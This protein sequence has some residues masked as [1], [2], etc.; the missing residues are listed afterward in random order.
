IPA[1]LPGTA[2]KLLDNAQGPRWS[3]DGRHLAFMRPGSTSGDELWIADADGSNAHQVVKPVGGRH[4]HW[5][6]WS[7]DGQYVYFIYSPNSFND[8]PAEI[9]RVPSAGGPIQR[10]VATTR[11]AVFPAPLLDGI[12]Y[13][14][15]AAGADLG[16]WW[17]RN[18]GGES[19]PVTAGIGE[20]ADVQ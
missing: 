15:D 19:L 4:L 10:V 11:R 6:A 16:L 18:S 8:Q 3:A 12:I 7:S 5:P 17:R 14:A 1:P 2:R 20:Y 13:A 9:F